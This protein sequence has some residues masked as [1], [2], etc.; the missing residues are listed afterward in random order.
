MSRQVHKLVEDLKEKYEANR[1]PAETPW[2][3]VELILKQYFPES[4]KKKRGSH[5]TIHDDR[6]RSPVSPRGTLT[7]CH[8]QGRIVIKPYVK[9]LIEAIIFM[10]EMHGEQER[11]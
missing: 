8:R 6:L 4:Y 9:N 1:I 3:D 5:I 11:P 2:K 7:I 10:E